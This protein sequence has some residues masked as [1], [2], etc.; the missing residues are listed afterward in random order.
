M[1]RNRF[2]PAASTFRRALRL[3]KILVGLALLGYLVT[4]IE[5]GEFLQVLERSRYELVLVGLAAFGLARCFDAVRLQVIVR[6]Y[7]LRFASALKIVMVSIFFNNLSTSVVGDG[8]KVCA[9][10]DKIRNWRAPVTFV[11]LE[12]FAGMAVMSLLGAGYVVLYPSRASAFVRSLDLK[13]RVGSGLLIGVGLVMLITLTLLLVHEGARPYRA[14]VID[15]L[16]NMYVIVRAVT[17]SAF[18]SVLLVTAVSHLIGALMIYVL[19]LAVRGEVQFFDI[20]FV[21][22]LTYMAAYVPVS[23]GALGVREA[24]LVLGLTR[25]GLTPPSAMAVALI[26]RIIIYAY[27]VVGGLLPQQRLLSEDRTPAP[28]DSGNLASR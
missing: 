3:A 23:I 6:N 13:F 12:R 7:A 27:A 26:S 17:G 10:R 1:A 18:V 16:R 14:Y 5:F 22:I 8:Y 25:F 11:V 2:E 19:A 4:L 20:I 15:R 21:M 9:L 28:E 24:F